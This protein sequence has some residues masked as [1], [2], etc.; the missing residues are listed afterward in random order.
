[1]PN[2]FPEGTT[3]SV[4]DDEARSYKKWNQF[5][6]DLNGNK[7]PTQF[8]EGSQPLISDDAQR[9]AIKIDALLGP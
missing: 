6:Y 8:P 4:W 5:L 9:S 1:M 3:P 2:L 7:G